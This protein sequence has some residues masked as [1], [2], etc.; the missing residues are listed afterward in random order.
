MTVKDLQGFLEKITYYEEN[1]KFVK[2]SY[3]SNTTQRMLWIV[4]RDVPSLNKLLKKKKA[5]VA[6]GRPK[7]V[8]RSFSSL[9]R[10]K[11]FSQNKMEQDRLSDL[12]L[13]SSESQLLTEVMETKSFQDSVITEFA[14]VEKRM[15][16]TFK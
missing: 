16:V 14:S 15:E 12:G 2:V 11:S 1:L 7:S 5:V 8:E 3:N 13:I 9:K 10:I 6:A 4:Y